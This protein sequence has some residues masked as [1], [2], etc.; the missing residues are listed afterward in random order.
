LGQRLIMAQTKPAKRNLSDMLNDVDRRTLLSPV[1]PVAVEVVVAEAPTPPSTTA[2]VTSEATSKD[3][4]TPVAEASK[5]AGAKKAADQKKV[6]VE[7]NRRR[8]AARAE[9]NAT[10][11][12]FQRKEARLTLAQLEFATNTAIKLNRGAK[13]QPER[14]TSNTLIR[15]ALDL[16]IS[17]K[18]KLAGSTEEELRK[19]LGL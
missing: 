15:V 11:L 3:G 7:R 1:E 12:Q 10:Y 13:S 8:E 6:P 19:S 14:I 16:L 18:D 2:P 9:S 5:A 4:P 17:Q